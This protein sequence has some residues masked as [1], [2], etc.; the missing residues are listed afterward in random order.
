MI[1]LVTT[2]FSAVELNAQ[3]TTCIP[4]SVGNSNDSTWSEE[5]YFNSSCSEQGNPCTANDVNLLG[6]YLADEFGD[7]L[8]IFTPGDIVDVYL[9]GSFENGTGYIKLN[10]M[11]LFD[12]NLSS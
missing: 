5:C 1:A 10:N 6:T 3:S 7:P 12:P 2:L 9:W 4:G 8:P 11:E